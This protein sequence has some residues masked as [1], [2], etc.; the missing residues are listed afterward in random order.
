MDDLEGTIHK[1]YGLFPTFVYVIDPEG[2]VAFRMPWNVPE[3]LDEVLKAMIEKKIMRFPETY[4]FPKLHNVGFRA[5]RRSG[6]QALWDV[7]PN[8]P[9]GLWTRY[10]LKKLSRK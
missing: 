1:Q 10:R 2:Y 9:R 4:E 6:W 8:I 7:L 3:R 5:L